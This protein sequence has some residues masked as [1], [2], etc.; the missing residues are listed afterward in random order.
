MSRSAL[1]FLYVVFLT[2][3]SQPTEELPTETVDLTQ[4]EPAQVYEVRCAGCHEQGQ[5][6]APP[7]A[8]LARKNPASV[9]FAMR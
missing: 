4:A 2:A 9:A 3:C 1:A 7:L 6:K 5:G 8:T